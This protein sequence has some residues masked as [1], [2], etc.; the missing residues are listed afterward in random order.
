MVLTVQKTVEVPLSLWQFIGKIID[1]PVVVQRQITIVQIWDTVKA[2]WCRAQTSESLGTCTSSPGGISGNCG[3][4]RDRRGSTGRIRA[5][6]VRHG[7]CL[8][9]SASCCGVCLARS[10]CVD[11]VD[12]HTRGHVCTCL[13]RRVRDSS[14]TVLTLLHVPVASTVFPTATVRH[15]PEIQTF[16]KT[17]EIPL[18]SS[19]DKVVDSLLCRS[20]R[21]HRYRWHRRRLQRWSRSERLCLSPAKNTRVE[22]SGGWLLRQ[23]SRIWLPSPPRNCWFEPRAKLC[24]RNVLSVF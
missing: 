9:V 14:V 23:S 11:Y 19:I 2:T 10:R 22:L 13:S 5:T 8:G 20:Y 21:F 12:A 6:Q 18:L 7:T 17:M 4:D 1:I 15:V 16:Q 24:D 3:V